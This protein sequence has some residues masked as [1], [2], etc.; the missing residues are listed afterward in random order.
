MKTILSLILTLSLLTAK[1][2]SALDLATGSQVRNS[3]IFGNLNAAPVST[4]T[5]VMFS[6]SDSI[7][8]AGNNNVH[9]PA[10]PFSSGFGFEITMGSLVF[11]RGNQTYLNP[12]DTVD[13]AFNPRI[14]CEEVDIGAYEHL[15]L[16]TRITVQPTLAE[17]ICEGSAVLLQVEAVG[18]GITFQWQRNGVNLIGRTSPML[19]I[20]NVSMADT[21]DYRVIVFGACCNDTSNVVR[22][23]VDLKPMVVAMSDTTILSG[24]NVT[25]YVKQ[26]IG[27]VV[28][29]QSDM[30]T[31]V[32]NPNL[33]NIT[34]STQYFAVA[35][36]GV[37]LDT[38]IAPVKII[39][40][41]SV[42]R[43]QT[44]PDAT[45]CSGDPFRLLI[46]EA[47]VTARWFLEGTT[48]ELPNAAIVRPTETSRFVLVGFDGDG[49]ICARD[50][51]TLTVPTLDFTVMDN[52]KI[53][54]D[55]PIQLYSTPPADVWLNG[56]NEPVGGGHT[57]IVPPIGTT[58]IYTAQITDLV[59]GCV[60]RQ[61]VS[62]TANPP[63]LR[64][65][66]GTELAPQQ[67][68]LTICEGDLI[69]L[70][71]NIDPQ[72]ID[73]RKDPHGLNTPL[74]NDPSFPAIT[75]ETPTLFRGWAW[76]LVCGDTYLDIEIT[77][78]PRP[79][80]RVDPQPPIYAGT[81]VTLTSV[82]NTPIWTDLDGTRVLMPI[83]LQETQSFVG[84]FQQG[85][86]EV[87]DTILVEVMDD[88]P[89]PPPQPR[90][91]MQVAFSSTR[92]YQPQLRQ[93]NCN[94]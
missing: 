4:E 5:S 21:G 26:S 60:F 11:D 88:D 89:P 92:A 83:T 42:C 32:L 94:D 12:T 18:E 23:N 49:T 38:A 45:V 3:I 61:Q 44:Y 14:S 58:T 7:L 10:T 27:T 73:W 68:V 47:T 22:L 53:C 9:L 76:D 16:S 55:E 39:V 36:N 17:R 77:V 6:A 15:V 75:T 8:P 63:D 71:T 19:A 78:Q 93:C 30:E 28:W 35:T 34:E 90:I 87:R 82:P 33:T 85:A 91:A 1:A 2:Q 72:L 86:C 43:V 25:L 56:E 65:P 69:H 24:Q 57:T 62:V 13:V 81:T 20:T 52:A 66:I 51:L 46:Y 37:C 50:T 70:Q 84:V 67:Y 74:P 59:S 54:R 80:F 31:V 48:T 40:D 79:E 41:G 64:S 29:F